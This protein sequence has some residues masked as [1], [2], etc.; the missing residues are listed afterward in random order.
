MPRRK[1]TEEGAGGHKRARV[2]EEGGA[3][4]VIPLP[5]VDVEDTLTTYVA[6]LSKKW[7]PA[8]DQALAKE[9]NK[10]RKALNPLLVLLRP[11]NECAYMNTRD[12]LRASADSLEAAQCIFD[13]VTVPKN[14]EKVCEIQKAFLVARTHI[15]NA[16]CLLRFW[17]RD[18]DDKDDEVYTALNACIRE[19]NDIK[20]ILARL[21]K[22]A[23]ED[24]RA[25]AALRTTVHMATATFLIRSAVS[26]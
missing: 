26:K 20:P 25:Y 8:K 21:E 18:K 24:L 5:I 3:L 1:T 16:L 19:L 13:T 11:P 23:R 10:G 7:M 9:I 2:N 12:A 4:L 22:P 14:T 17:L 15:D 6:I